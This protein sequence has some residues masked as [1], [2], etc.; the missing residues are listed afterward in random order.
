MGQ[1]DNPGWIR[2]LWGACW[3]HRGLVV[4]SVLASV[5][6]V[7]FVALSPLLVKAVV[8]DAVDGSTQR[9]WWLVGGLA[10]LALL[11]F[12]SAFVR[13]YLGGRL[14]LDV[15]HDLRQAVF[16]AVQ[17]LDGGKQDALRTGQVVSRSITDLQLVQG[18]LMMVP[19]SIGTVV[20][21]AVALASMVWLSPLLT[22]IALV[23]FPAVVWI[24]ARMRRTLF[25]ATWSAQQRAADVA[26]HVEETVTGVR[27]VKGFG[28]ESR[29]V[30]NLRESARLLFAERMRAA[31]LTS[32]PAASLVALPIAGQVAV[33]AFGGLMAL[34]GEITLG[35]FLAFAGYVA[36]LVGPARLL[37]GLVVNAQLAR[38]GV[39]RVYELIDSQPDVT[40]SPDATAV[41]DGPLS[42]TLTNATFGYTRSDPVLNDL[43]L[44]VAP[45][46]TLALVGTAGSGKSTVSLLLPRFY[47]THSGTVEVGGVNVRDLTLASLRSTVGVVFEEAFL[48]SDT[49]AANIAYGRPTA[50][51]DDIHAAAKAAQAHD[52]IEALPQGY[53]TPVGERGL[54]L[55]GGQR[56]R[57]ALAR[58]LLTNPRILILD[59]ATSAIDPQTESAIHETLKEV[60]ATRT[61]ILIAHR[62][63]TLTL[64]T[65]IAVLDNGRLVAQGTHTHLTQT[66]PLYRSL[67]ATPTSA[68]TSPLPL[69]T[70]ASAPTSPLPLATPASAPTSPLP[71]PTPPPD[72]TSTLPTPAPSP[73]STSAPLASAPPTP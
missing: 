62:P 31:R 5:I 48:F 1:V 4:L 57:I 24:A 27:V 54:T 46:E 32:R 44:T 25:P 36:N 34:R 3:R 16:G 72:P 43:T 65:R 9:L 52:F 21:A 41:P 30:A 11:S 10:A 22:L 67:L 50:T 45:G 66:S 38:A 49:I 40:D 12:G 63:S 53:D 56:Q 28:R 19:L 23:V 59:D 13:R 42:V 17:R 7:G 14:A 71:L 26:Q 8:D 2:R 70:P 61:T 15:Q 64:A 58:A 68:P 55:S 39:E 60:T 35:T 33:L 20:F 69:A 37:A 18:L 47:D 73:T 6:G 29:E 51:P